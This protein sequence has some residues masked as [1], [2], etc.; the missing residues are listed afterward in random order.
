MHYHTIRRKRNRQ[1]YL[2]FQTPSYTELQGAPLKEIVS[3]EKYHASRNDIH[4]ILVLQEHYDKYVMRIDPSKYPETAD[5]K[6][7]DKD[8]VAGKGMSKKKTTSGQYFHYRWTKESAP[9]NQS[10]LRNC[11]RHLPAVKPSIVQ[12]PEHCTFH[13]VGGIRGN[14]HDLTEHLAELVRRDV[15]DNYTWKVLRENCVIVFR[16][17]LITSASGT[18]SGMYGYEVMCIVYKLLL[19]N[20][21]KVF[22]MRER[23]VQMASGKYKEKEECRALIQSKIPEFYVFCT[24]ESPPQDIVYVYYPTKEAM[25]SILKQIEEAVAVAAEG[26][27]V[28]AAEGDE[29]AEAEVAEAVA[30]EWEFDDDD[31]RYLDVDK[32][33]IQQQ[34]VVFR[35]CYSLSH[36]LAADAGAGAGAGGGAGGAVLEVR[37]NRND[38]VCDYKTNTTTPFSSLRRVY[39]H[40][41]YADG[42]ANIYWQWKLSTLRELIHPPD[43]DVGTVCAAEQYDAGTRKGYDDLKKVGSSLKEDTHCPHITSSLDLVKISILEAYYSLNVLRLDPRKKRLGL[44]SVAAAVKTAVGRHSPDNKTSYLEARQKPFVGSYLSAVLT[45]LPAT[46]PSFVTISDEEA[47]MIVIGDICGEVHVLVAYLRHWVERQIV[48]D[49]TWT[50]VDPTYVIVFT[51]NLVCDGECDYGYEASCIVYTLLLKNPG[52]VFV[53]RGKYDKLDASWKG[54]P[55]PP[56]LCKLIQEKIPLFYVFKMFEMDHIHIY[57]CQGLP[58]V[59]EMERILPAFNRPTPSLEVDAHVF[60]TRD[61]SN[62]YSYGQIT[63]YTPDST[64]YTV[65]DN[66]WSELLYHRDQIETRILPVG[67]TGEIYNQTDY[68]NCLIAGNMNTYALSAK[69]QEDAEYTDYELKDKEVILITKTDFENTLWPYTF[70]K[71]ER[72]W[73]W[74]EPSEPPEGNRNLNKWT[75]GTIQDT[76]PNGKY[77]VLVS[78]QSIVGAQNIV[79]WPEPSNKKTK[80]GDAMEKIHQPLKFWVVEAVKKM[81]AAVLRL[82]PLPGGVLSFWNWSRWSSSDETDLWNSEYQHDLI[83]NEL[84][85]QKAVVFRGHDHSFPSL[86]YQIRGDTECDAYP[87]PPPPTDTFAD[88]RRVYTHTSAMV[89]G[90]WRHREPRYWVWDLQM[91]DRCINKNENLIPASVIK[92]N[93]YTVAWH[94]TA[95]LAGC[96]NEHNQ[97]LFHY[98]CPFTE[99]FIDEKNIHDNPKQQTKLYSISDLEA[100]YRET[101]LRIQWNSNTKSSPELLQYLKLRTRAFDGDYLNNILGKISD[102]PPSS[103]TVTEQT[104]MIVIGDIH[105][106]VHILTAY[107]KD[108]VDRGVLDDVSWKVQRKDYLILFTGDL[109]DRGM[110]GVE[111]MCIVYTLLQR[112]PGF[113][114]VTRGNHDEYD[115]E[116]LWTRWNTIYGFGQAGCFARDLYHDTENWIANQEDSRCTDLGKLLERKIPLFYVFN[117]TCRAPPAAPAEAEPPEATPFRIYACH[118]LPCIDDM[119][120]I[121]GALKKE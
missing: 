97:P 74:P 40:H 24:H 58:T 115:P 31:S 12:V 81:A 38:V 18:A 75:P 101:V 65:R 5:D 77:V 64:T 62:F 6:D 69:L 84:I 103:V 106:D 36:E 98:G 86:E 16:G 42:T 9:F 102:T 100:R 3:A 63:A 46:Q 109:V 78:S 34:A 105:G 13:V 28:A 99:L 70:K 11:L 111:V 110:Y 50:V 53:T 60:V 21:G 27:E 119:N 19:K 61:G 55:D 121:D 23:V 10:E 114:F 2:Q 89:L 29:V 88:L 44:A 1:E 94:T 96:N 117:I 57:A 93:H 71:G 116:K 7:K 39:T 52:R 47:K 41:T 90:G 54:V 79:S 108:W 95:S 32:K 120:F 43:L 8:E 72:V 83:N 14:V 20:P 51:G 25:A 59:A 30:V 87:Y 92:L 26:D 107:L 17:D 37:M 82:P 68:K 91:L 56:G 80:D 35:G 4:G 22:V 49:A 33:L 85:V 45:Q 113:V 104:K 118:G 112:N 66:I 48:D 15:V 76:L 73:M 67:T